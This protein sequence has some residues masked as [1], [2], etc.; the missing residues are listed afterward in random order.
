MLKQTPAS[1][2]AGILLWSVV[3]LPGCNGAAPT[4]VSVG[5]TMLKLTSSSFQGDRIPTKFTC[6]GAG[7]SPQLAWTGPPPATASLALLVTDPDAP[8]GPFVHWVL[9]NLPSATREIPEGQPPSGARLG[10]NDFGNIGYGG[11]CPPGKSPHRYVFSL[12]AL[13]ASLNLPQGATLAEVK[14][15]MQGHV[16]AHGELIALYPK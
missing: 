8:G 10:R 11:P 3:C 13:D 14:S 4:P 2:L 15:A 16:L 9:F 12:Y 1:R 6:D 7:T 5:Q